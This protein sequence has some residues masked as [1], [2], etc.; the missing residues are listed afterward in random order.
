MK[1]TENKAL[2]TYANPLSLPEIPFGTDDW[3]A[4]QPGMF[5]GLPQAAGEPEP[6]LPLHQ[7]PHGLL[8]GGEV[9]P[10]SQLRHG[11]GH[12]GF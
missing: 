1:T 10:L 9:V 5:D 12:G 7:R 3:L 11:L 4:K 8:L 2:H 6:G